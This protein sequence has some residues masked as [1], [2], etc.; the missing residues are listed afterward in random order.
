MISRNGFPHQSFLPYISYPEMQ[1]QQPVLWLEV[2]HKGWE[3]RMARE[4]KTRKSSQNGSGGKGP[5][6]S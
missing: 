1:L 6:G 4:R 5:Q 3:V 2:V